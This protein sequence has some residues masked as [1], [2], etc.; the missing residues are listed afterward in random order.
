[1][2]KYDVEAAKEDVLVRLQTLAVFDPAGMLGPALAFRQ[3]EL[4]R[5]ALRNFRT[6]FGW[7]ERLDASSGKKAMVAVL[8]DKDGNVRHEDRRHPCLVGSIPKKGLEQILLETLLHLIRLEEQVH[9]IASKWGELASSFVSSSS[10]STFPIPA[11]AE[12]LNFHRISSSSVGCQILLK[13]TFTRECFPP[14]LSSSSQRWDAPTVTSSFS[15]T[16]SGKHVACEP[17]TLKTYRSISIYDLVPLSFLD[18]IRWKER[19]STAL[20]SRI[21]TRRVDL[22]PLSLLLSLRPP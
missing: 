1:M 4:V 10:P 14:P 11:E 17:R 18:L 3:L 16:A 8:V 6:E 15:C 9:T 13:F 5:L 20:S 12:A 22:V 7:V 21:K 19:S 2:Q